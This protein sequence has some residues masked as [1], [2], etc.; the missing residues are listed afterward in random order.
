MSARSMK[1]SLP[2]ITTILL[3]TISDSLC[4]SALGAP[5]VPA[6]G[7]EAFS[8]RIVATGLEGPW[9]IAWG[10]DDHLWVVERRGKRVTRV[11]P[12]DGSRSVVLNIPEAYQASGQDGVLGMALHPE[13]LQETG[14][15]YVYLAFVYDADAGPAIV[16]RAKIRRYTYDPH[17]QT[18]GSPVDLLADLPASD[19]H[20][21][22]RLVFGPDRKLYYSIGDQGSN[23]RGNKCNRNRAQDLP[24]A[25]EV[26]ANDF[27]KYQGKILRLNLDG[28]IPADNP[29]IGGARSHI[30]SYGHRNPQGLAFGPDGQLYSSEHGPKTDDE[31]NLIQAGKNYGWPYVAGYQDDQAY[32]YGNWSASSPVPCSSLEYSPFTIPPSVPQQRESAWHDPDFIPPL[33]SLFV[34]P[35]DY[36][37]QDPACA[38]REYICF[39]SLALSGIE[40]YAAGAH[41]I[42]G[43]SNSILAASLKKGTLYRL[44]LSDDGRSIS[45]DAIPLFRT[46]NRYRDLAIAPDKQTIYIATDKGDAAGPGGGWTEVLDNPGAILEFRYDA[47]APSIQ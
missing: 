34:V 11:D 3:L 7:Q 31:I 27:S 25:A 26:L 4:P 33:K 22:G 29:T 24:S 20:N 43:W 12:L 14:Q 46:T 30:Y 35:D 28:S 45:G 39:P 41:G 1:S 42:P 10:P 36:N 5:A 16:R 44:P 8:F 13:L 9:E 47:V 21:A 15:D 38:G 40:V 17:S 2:V 32:V 6:A 23:Q 37:F 18:L 19:D